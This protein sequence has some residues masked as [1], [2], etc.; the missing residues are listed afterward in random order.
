M[1]IHMSQ[2]AA[3]A[4]KVSFVITNE[5]KEK[6]EFVVLQTDRPPQTASRS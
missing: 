2:T 1:Y 3:P 4:G 6:H 5:G